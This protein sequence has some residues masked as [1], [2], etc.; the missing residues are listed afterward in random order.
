M[1]DAEQ[2]QLLCSEEEEEMYFW[3]SSGVH[4]SS[5]VSLALSF[6][7]GNKRDFSASCQGQRRLRAAWGCILHHPNCWGSGRGCTPTSRGLAGAKLPWYMVAHGAAWMGEG[8]AAGTMVQCWGG[9][10]RR[11][12]G[13]LPA[14]R[15]QVDAFV[16]TSITGAAFD[17]SRDRVSGLQQMAFSR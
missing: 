13:A 9:C 12:Q 11:G 14:R 8:L 1:H 17:L 3:A 10:G 16:C 15:C 5:R 6:V 4:P 7:L 2:Q